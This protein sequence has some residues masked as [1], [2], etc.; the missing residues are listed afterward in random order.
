M[1]PCI[2]TI[3]F[4]FHHSLLTMKNFDV[5]ENKVRNRWNALRESFKIEHS[6]I[7]KPRSGDPAS[8]LNYTVPWS[9]YARLTFLKDQILPFTSTGNLTNRTKNTDDPPDKRSSRIKRANR[10]SDYE[11]SS[12]EEQGS[13]VSL[14]D[15]EED[16]NSLDGQEDD[17]SDENSEND[18]DNKPVIHSKKSAKKEKEE[19]STKAGFRTRVLNMA[20]KRTDILKALVENGTNDNDT[21]LLLGLRPHFDAMLPEIKMKCLEE[22]HA[23][24]KKYAGITSTWKNQE[25]TVKKKLKKT[26]RK[27]DDT[28]DLTKDSDSDSRKSPPALMHSPS[29]ISTSSR[30][31]QRLV[32]SPRSSPDPPSPIWA[33]LGMKT[34]KRD[35]SP[36]SPSKSPSP[37]HYENVSLSSSPNKSGKGKGTMLK[38]YFYKPVNFSISIQVIYKP[39]HF[40]WFFKFEW[41]FISFFEYIL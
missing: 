11:Y 5:S 27:T 22:L 20:E 28:V 7:P 37:K 24:V 30:K 17:Q 10:N 6:L 9:L 8:I 41:F 32:P 40:E 38:K 19:Q 25:S 18:S 1:F 12:A 3:L 33:K 23:V 13:D 26:S 35:C 34:P 31:R 15:E 2:Y 29:D 39:V 36:R 14:K 21:T 16:D 4:L